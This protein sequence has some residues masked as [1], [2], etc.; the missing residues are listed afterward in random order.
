ML[1]SSDPLTANLNT[2]CHSCAFLQVQLRKTWTEDTAEPVNANSTSECV[3]SR[4]RGYQVRQGVGRG[5]EDGMWPDTFD[6][7]PELH[8]STHQLQLYAGVAS[9]SLKQRPFYLLEEPLPSVM[10]WISLKSL[11]LS[12]KVGGFS[13]WCVIYHAGRNSVHVV[14]TLELRALSNLQW[15]LKVP[16]IEG[17]FFS[18]AKKLSGFVCFLNWE[19]NH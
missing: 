7:S 13:A 6:L 17:F 10:W 2:A 19:S 16:V 5:H 3:G 1:P 8:G 11:A 12:E 9:P 18:I 4:G 14:F 15:N